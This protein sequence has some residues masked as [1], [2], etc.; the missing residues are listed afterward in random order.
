MNVLFD[1][2]GTLTD[3]FEGITR[4]ISHALVALGK[5]PPPRESLGWCIGPPLRDSFSKLLDSEEKGLVEKALSFYRER[6]G[7]VGLFENKVYPGIP[8]ALHDLRK[9]GHTLY[10]ATAKPEVYAERIIDHFNLSSHFKKIY[11][12]GLDGT[13][14]SKIELIAHILATE[15]LLPHETA[16]IGD[17]KFDITGAKANGVYGLAALWGYGL[18]EELEGMAPTDFLENPRDILAAIHQLSAI[19]LRKNGE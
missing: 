2:D 10:V 1:L 8:D 3:P 6:F 18:R 15:S 19:V 16:M 13:R 7:T 14:T 5:S 9:K 4:C 12:S 11:G 17:R